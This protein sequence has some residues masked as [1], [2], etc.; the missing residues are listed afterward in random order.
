MGSCVSRPAYMSPSL[1]PES[2]IR[3]V[4]MHLRTAS[5]SLRQSLSSDGYARKPSPVPFPTPHY[6]SG[7]AARQVQVRKRIHVFL[8]SPIC[9]SQ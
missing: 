1:D 4:A 3:L 5:L 7:G 6:D 2:L 8:V 9:P